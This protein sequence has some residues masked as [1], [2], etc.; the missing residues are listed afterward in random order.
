[1]NAYLIWFNKKKYT[2]KFGD[3][4]RG[5]IK[6]A[7]KAKKSAGKAIKN[8]KFGNITRSIFRKVKNKIRSE[9]SIFCVLL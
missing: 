6:V 7:S 2:Y 3:I 8:Y 1:M 5:T 9:T 4:T